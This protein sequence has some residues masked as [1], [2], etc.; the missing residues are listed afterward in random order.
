MSYVISLYHIVFA[1]RRREPVID[2]T[3]SQNLYRVIA[4]E[5]AK[6]KSKALIINGV[7]DHIHILLQLSPQ[8]ALSD[9]V[10]DIKSKSSVW[11][12]SSG[13]F[14]LFD[15][16]Q[17]EYGAFSLS[18]NHRDAVYQYILSQKEHH[19]NNDLESE[20]RRLLMKAG[21]QLYEQ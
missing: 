17:K 12:K 13:L 20:F 3:Y 11:M 5:I 2:E 18:A 15:G 9:L 4:S 19:A 7:H 1:T 21:L 8:I 10:R 16:W 6:S 14:P